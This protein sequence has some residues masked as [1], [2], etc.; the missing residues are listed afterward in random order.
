LYNAWYQ[1]ENARKNL[2]TQ[3]NSL[4]SQILALKVKLNNLGSNREDKHFAF[5]QET[6][7]EKLDSETEWICVKQNQKKRKYADTFK[8]THSPQNQSSSTSRAQV[9][10]PN[11]SQKQQ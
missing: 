10:G 4:Q 11:R 1:S 6:E 2:E 8:P 5:T 9:E 3:V 7:E